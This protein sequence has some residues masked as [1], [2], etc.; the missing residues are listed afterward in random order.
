MNEWNHTPP[1]DYTSALERLEGDEEFLNELLA[2]YQE[3]FLEKQSL[4]IA[5]V[6]RNDFVEIAKLGHGLK[7]GSANLSLTQLRETASLIEAA[8]KECDPA[9]ARRF[10]NRLMEEFKR[11]Q[12][13]LNK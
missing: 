7:G 2:I 11:L 5:A 8:G 1:I 12:E 9:A 13:F 4:L 10:I 3:D 6:E